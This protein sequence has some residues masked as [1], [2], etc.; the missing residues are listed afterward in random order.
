MMI[1]KVSIVMPVLNADQFLEHTLAS[2]RAQTFQDW[3]LIVVDDGSTDQSLDIL[4]KAA[5]NDSRISVLT[6]AHSRQAGAARN[7]GLDQA[8]G[9]YIAFLDADDLW[10][11]T[12]LATQIDFMTQQACTFSC[13]AFDVIDIK[14]R[15][16]GTRSVPKR[17][18]FNDLLLCNTIGTSTVMIAQD[19]LGTRRFPALK[20]RQD[21]ALWLTVLSQDQDC[22]GLDIP[23]T[24]YR[25]HSGS[26]S[27]SKLRA[28][29]AT[30]GVYKTLPGL[31]FGRALWSYA[32][33]VVRTSIK[34]SKRAQPR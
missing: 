7:T 6:H 3:E 14:G 10:D 30:W 31:G 26:L 28:I 19:L 18:A 27:A 4:R 16:I 12:K 5:A 33:Y 32:N 21:Y 13:T 2:V 9:Q 15:R 29:V 24:R 1:P 8:T 11:Q 17:V 23:L 25:R 34:N 20:R 22:L